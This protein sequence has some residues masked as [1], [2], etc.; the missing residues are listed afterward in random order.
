MMLYSN[1]DFMRGTNKFLNNQGFFLFDLGS[2]KNPLLQLFILPE[3]KE[4]GTYVK[5][6][7]IFN[8]MTCLK[9][10]WLFMQFALGM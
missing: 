9:T 5:E 4:L 7:L 2:V 3:C 10:T 8:S 6:T 1:L